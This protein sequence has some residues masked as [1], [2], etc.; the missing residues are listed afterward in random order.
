M[1]PNVLLMR[2][3]AL[4][5]AAPF[6]YMIGVGAD[7]PPGFLTGLLLTSG[8]NAVYLAM[9]ALWKPE[10]FRRL[11]R[12]AVALETLANGVGMGLALEVVFRW[13]NPGQFLTALAG[14][15]VWACIAAPVGVLIRRWLR[16]RPELA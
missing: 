8:G 15:A 12:G 6:V 3:T 10:T 13:G 7:L 5:I 11:H 4:A 2:M 16:T 14:A 1:L 9:L